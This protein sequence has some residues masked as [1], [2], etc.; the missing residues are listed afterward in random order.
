MNEN[1]RD[2]LIAAGAILDAQPVP[3]NNR[4]VYPDAFEVDQEEDD[5]LAGTS[6][7]ALPSA[8]MLENGACESCQ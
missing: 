2:V 4:I 8:C 5:F 6:A 3:M 1:T 7:D